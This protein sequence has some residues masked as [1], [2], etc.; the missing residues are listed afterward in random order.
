MRPIFIHAVAFRAGRRRAANRKQRSGPQ[1]SRTELRGDI[2][3]ATTLCHFLCFFT[4]PQRKGSHSVVDGTACK[5]PYSSKKKKKRGLIQGDPKDDQGFPIN[6]AGVESAET[7]GADERRPAMIHHRCTRPASNHPIRADPSARLTL[8]PQPA[9]PSHSPLADR[10]VAATLFHTKGSPF[11]TVS[12]GQAPLEL[13][14]SMG[15][16]DD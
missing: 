11:C 16:F 8:F 10:P 3:K 13:H 2:A 4:L 7:Q 9:A 14:Y 12:P 6:R 15:C 5:G 1:N